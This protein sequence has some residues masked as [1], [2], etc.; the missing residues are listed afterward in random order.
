M[1][2]PRTTVVID[3]YNYG[4]FIEEAIDSVL[5][6]D[7]PP[8]ELEII[9]VD[10]GSTDDTA[11]RIKKYGSRIQYLQKTN[12]GQASAFNVGFA[13]ARGEFIVLLDADDYFL[14]GKLRRIV[15]AFESH[16]EV[17]MIYHRLPEMHAGG[18]MTPAQGFEQLSGFLPSSDRKL[19]SYS[20]HQTS[21]L[22]F[23]RSALQDVLPMPESMRIQADV[24]LELVVVLSKPILAIPEELAVY[25]IHEKNLCAGD[26]I[27]PSPEGVKRLL[28]SSGTVKREIEQWI[29]S[30]KGNSENA[31]TQRLLDR[32]VLPV[33]ERKFAFYPPSRLHYFEFLMRR[34]SAFRGTRGWHINGLKHL[35]ALSALIL[36]YKKS[37][38][39]HQ[40]FARTL[41]ASSPYRGQN[42]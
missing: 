32:L 7:F 31:A 15:A 3:T 10:D 27:A 9:V 12:G 11:G 6:Q 36:G 26:Y 38:L 39:F 19:S 23:R 37:F 40:W 35:A 16:P 1:T 34:N 33:I 8:E 18:V 22:S 14:P 5:S 17:G 13:Q 25:R 41:N 20:A 30:H 28:H 2:T 21:C 4:R 24:Y 29:Q 42:I